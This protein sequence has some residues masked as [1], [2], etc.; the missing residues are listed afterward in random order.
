MMETPWFRC[1]RGTI[2]PEVGVK[3]QIFYVDS[4][5]AQFVKF[6]TSSVKESFEGHKCRDRRIITN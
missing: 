5:Q 3:N 6:A 4:D 2:I 1:E